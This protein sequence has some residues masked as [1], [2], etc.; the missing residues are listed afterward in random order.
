M[1]AV[2]KRYRGARGIEDMDLELRAGEVFAFLGPNGAG[3]TTTIR[4]LLD[5]IRPDAGRVQLFGL[6]VRR[7]GVEVRRRVGYLPGELG[8]Y[9]QLTAREILSHFA[10]LRGAGRSEPFA[11]LAERFELELSRPVRSLSK[12]NRQK[13]ALVQA[14]MG[15]PELLILD[16]PTTGLDPLVQDQVHATIRSAARSGRSVFL[17]SHVLSEVASV[18]DRVGIIS[19]G[20]IAR[21]VRIEELRAA[22]VHYVDVRFQGQGGYEELCALSNVRITADAGA[23]M[24]IEVTGS[25]D[26]VIAVLARY[27]IADL[28]IRETDLETV[29]RGALGRHDEKPGR[30]AAA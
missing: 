19:D 10:Y 26:P 30:G 3:K 4:I 17:S 11:E 28:T 20:R 1:E 21:L 25:L 13:V 14:L 27:A 23:T 8:L 12:G 6:D 18:A 24:S 5:L 7:H 2:T 9:E 29:F 15:D 16:E 22:A